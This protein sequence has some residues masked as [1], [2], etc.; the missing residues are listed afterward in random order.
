MPTF[1]IKE[2]A[3]LLGVSH[4]TLR[5]WADAGRIATTTDDSGRM[6]VDGAALAQFAQE[7]AESADSADNKVVVAHSA[8]NRFQ[9][10]ISKV[11]RDTVMAQV[12]IQ[13]GPHRFVSLLSREAADEL[14]LEPGMLAVATIKATNVSVDVPHSS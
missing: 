14:G 11:T 3:S 13:A 9:G 4:D 10:L 6:A 2:A 7:L 12:E 8:R 5:R 1:R